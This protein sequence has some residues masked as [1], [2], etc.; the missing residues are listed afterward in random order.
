MQDLKAFTQALLRRF[1]RANR[2]LA[3]PSPRASRLSAPK[4][5]WSDS[6]LS[7][8]PS[9]SRI[10]F[11]ELDL[12][13]VMTAYHF[14]PQENRGATESEEQKEGIANAGMAVA[15]DTKVVTK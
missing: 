2:I 1:A 3:I 14:V 4:R 10:G 11:V 13:P 12:S 5:R 9:S 15:T 7:L 8:L 6:T